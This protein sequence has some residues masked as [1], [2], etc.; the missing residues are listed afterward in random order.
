MPKSETVTTLRDVHTAFA[1]PLFDPCSM[2]FTKRALDSSSR[3]MVFL[4]WPVFWQPAGDESH[5]TML[6]TTPNE[7]V[8]LF[9]HRMP[10]ILLSAHWETW[11]GDDWKTV[12]ENPD[13]QPL[14]QNLNA[15]R[16]VLNGHP[17]KSIGSISPEVSYCKSMKITSR[18][19]QIFL[20]LFAQLLHRF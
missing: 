11:L 7:T 19:Q 10:F 20:A 9:H 17:F 18:L 12:L 8:M 5:F 1:K 2:D 6:T 4:R 16:T 15:A 3:A 13:K 14:K